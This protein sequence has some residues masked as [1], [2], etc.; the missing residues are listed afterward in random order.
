MVYF[1]VELNS[2]KVVDTTPEERTWQSDNFDTVKPV[3]SPLAMA[4]EFLAVSNAP[5]KKQ[6]K[7]A[8]KNKDYTK[9]VPYKIAK[10]SDYET[11]YQNDI[12]A[13][14]QCEKDKVRVYLDREKKIIRRALDNYQAAKYCG[15]P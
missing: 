10:T 2:I 12:K 14:R 7:N 1:R 6:T 9:R 15:Q 5:G 3:E 13:P 11:F 8:F 4:S